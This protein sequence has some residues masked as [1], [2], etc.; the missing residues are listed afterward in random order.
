MS[1][2]SVDS[3]ENS[4]SVAPSQTSVNFVREMNFVLHQQMLLVENAYRQMILAA[5]GYRVYALKARK[6]FD[7]ATQELDQYLKTIERTPNIPAVRP[8]AITSKA[9]RFVTWQYADSHTKSLPLSSIM[10]LTFTGGP[11][12]ECVVFDILYVIVYLCPIS[13][14]QAV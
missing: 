5:D 7:K 8:Q 10:H 12:R 13:V 9:S 1:S 14:R 11:S 4:S 3:D 2:S 6:Q